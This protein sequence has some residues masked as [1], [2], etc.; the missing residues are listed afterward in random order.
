MFERFTD[1]ARRAA[2]YAQD[3]ARRFGHDYVGTE[4]ILLGLLRVEDCVAAKVLR[5]QNISLE[6]VG[7]QME[8]I[9]GRGQLAPTGH[10]PFT[11]RAK[12]V[13]DFS[14][15]EALQ[16]G[17]TYIGTEH[18][19]LGI[20]RE[21]LGVAA[22]ILHKQASTRDLRKD[23]IAEGLVDVSTGT[24]VTFANPLDTFESISEHAAEFLRNTPPPSLPSVVEVQLRNLPQVT[25]EGANRYDTDSDHVLHLWAGGK[26]WDIRW[27][28]ADRNFDDRIDP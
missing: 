8:E 22:L 5:A 4:H 11:P 28:R 25:Y 12:K 3:E 26:S 7:L 23:V 10:I 24:S 14:L 1:Q 16:L 15:R 9:V 21:D 20:L 19:L 18:I 2:V 6:F 17:H 13:L 27:P